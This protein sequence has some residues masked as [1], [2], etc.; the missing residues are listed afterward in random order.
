MTARDFPLREL[1]QAA[2]TVAEPTETETTAARAK[3]EVAISAERRALRNNWFRRWRFAAAA[4]LLVL[5]AAAVVV[6]LLRAPSVNA[7]L[8]DLA[9]ATR[10]LEPSQLAPGEFRYSTRTSLVLGATTTAEG[11]LLAYLLPSTRE[12]W[13]DFDGNAVITTSVGNPRFF[14]EEA[15]ARYYAE[16]FDRT[17]RVGQTFTET[18]A[19]ISDQAVALAWPSDPESLRRT[20]TNEIREGESDLPE[21]VELV[22]LAA[23]I[24]LDAPS[25][26]QLRAGVIDVLATLD[27]ID[28]TRNDDDTTTVS[29]TYLDND[30]T[31]TDTA[32]IDGDG[33]LVSETRTRDSGDDEL[34]IP[35]GTFITSIDYTPP[36]IVSEVG[37]RPTP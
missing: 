3:L 35:P 15:E 25:T 18:F 17:D 28:V 23:R 16:G 24:L 27:E 29:I 12:I 11:E 22:E 19:G 6:P 14:S 8:A 9:S 7:T 1:L 36:V 26:P 32:T 31:T 20:M 33:Q 13:R 30:I 34:G 5:F 2:T 4:A 10:T 37:E 21:S